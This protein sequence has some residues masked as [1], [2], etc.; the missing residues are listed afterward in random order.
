MKKSLL[1]S[2]LLTLSAC[3]F[4]FA[5]ESG[6][7]VTYQPLDGLASGTIHIAQVTCH[8]WYRLGG[9]ATQIPLISAPNVPPTNNPK[10]ATQD[11]NLASLSGLKFRTS[12]LGGSSITAH[13]VTLDA[14][15][16]KVPPNAGHPRE[17]LVRASL[18]CLRL[19]LPEKLQQTPLTL[20][21][22]E[23]DQPWLTQI[24]AD[25]NSKD[26][27]KVFFTPAE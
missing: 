20:E 14:T 22:R 12:D 19:C 8:D 25:F 27:A 9:G 5:G 4:T 15:H 24:V 18:E 7:T 10:E 23:A 21:C 13:S 16:F 3:S 2:F 17:D 26:R 11:L 6:L 1:L